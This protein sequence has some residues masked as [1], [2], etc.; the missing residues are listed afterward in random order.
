MALTEA[1]REH[2]YALANEQVRQL[3]NELLE[4]DV[5][6]Q[7]VVRDMQRVDGEV[8]ARQQFGM[9][10]SM[11]TTFKKEP[12]RLESAQLDELSARFD[13]QMVELSKIFLNEKTDMLFQHSKEVSTLNARIDQLLLQRS[14]QQQQ[15]EQQ[16]EQQQQQQ[17]VD[18][19]CQTDAVVAEASIQVTT[20]RRDVDVQ[21]DRELDG[22][23]RAQA[24]V[25]TETEWPHLDQ[26]QREH[27]QTLDM[28]QSRIAEM[29][30]EPAGRA[31]QHTQTDPLLLPTHDSDMVTRKELVEI[32][33]KYTKE[34]DALVARVVALTIEQEQ[35]NNNLDLVE[36]ERHTRQKRNRSQGA[37]TDID[38]TRFADI[39]SEVARAQTA[40]AK[41]AEM[42]SALDVLTSL[43]NQ[44]TSSRASGYSSR[45][46]MEPFKQ[47]RLQ[48]Q[49]QQQQHAYSNRLRLLLRDL[50]EADDDDDYDDD[51]RE[52]SA[53]RDK[54][55]VAME[56][57][58]L[59]SSNGNAL[60][61]ASFKVA[62]LDDNTNSN[63]NNNNTNMSD[64]VDAF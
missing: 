5:R 3:I 25:Q 50:I 40:S 42:L 47:W 7:E 30:K 10:K 19:T 41:L 24:S 12:V 62:R 45:S 11:L 32:E 60:L 44:L 15:Q 18:A 2:V 13:Q 9:F 64:S 51:K 4:I 26:I 46:E 55:G 61:K 63:N 29:Q 49:Q 53:E 48:Q 14:P 21:T 38:S 23:R 57:G 43:Y 6:R 35:K 59:S 54:S 39:L 33:A 31:E 16:Q 37:Q 8:S 58:Y 22:K 56:L 28:L 1:S 36:F 34:N 17:Q 27:Q 52:V 20:Q